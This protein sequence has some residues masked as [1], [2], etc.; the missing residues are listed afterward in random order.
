MRQARNR[1][2]II[3][4]RLEKQYPDFITAL[5]WEEPWQLVAAVL[6][7][8]QTTDENVNSVT[9]NLFKKYRSPQE[10]AQTPLKALEKDVYSTGYYRA[11]ARNLKG[12]CVKL[13]EE[14]GGVVPDSLDE[15]ITLPGVGRKTANVVLHVLF[16]K[17]EGIVMDTHIARLTHRLGFIDKKSPALGE[18]TMMQ[19]LPNNLWREWGDL[20]I[21]HGR[22]IC[23]ARKPLCEKCVLQDLCPSAHSFE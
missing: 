17:R 3:I 6:L 16:D 23:D 8:A 5:D 11:K 4:K 14:F 9:K 20:L 22:E 12:M 1:A 18:K 2:K 21:Q 7:S 10:I 15:L 19:V 13:V